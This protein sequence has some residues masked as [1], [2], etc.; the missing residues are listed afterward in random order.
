MEDL[1]EKEEKVSLTVVVKK[2][3]REKV[4][5]LAQQHDVSLSRVVEVLLEKGLGTL[6]DVERK[7]VS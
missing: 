1:F 6:K 3:L 5:Q 2:E 4:E 7:E